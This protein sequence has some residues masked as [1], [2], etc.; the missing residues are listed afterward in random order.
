ML[1]TLLEK[2]KSL[3]L[4]LQIASQGFNTSF[5][6]MFFGRGSIGNLSLQPLTFLKD[7]LNIRELEP[8]NSDFLSKSSILK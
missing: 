6:G 2:D 8:W 1:L 4:Q 7:I 5:D 3:V